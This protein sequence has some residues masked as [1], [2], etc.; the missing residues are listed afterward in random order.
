M[1]DEPL[2]GPPEE[3]RRHRLPA[4]RRAVTHK[5]SIAGHE[6]YITVG[7]YP[8]GRPGEVFVKMAKSGSALRGLMDSWATAVSMM[9]QYGIPLRVIVTKFCFARFEPDGITEHAPVRFARSPV[10]YV[11][12]YM[13]TKYLPPDELASVLPAL[14]PADAKTLPA[15]VETG[16]ACAQC[17]GMLVL[18]EDTEQYVCDT[19]GLAEGEVLPSA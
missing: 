15:G 14:T 3:P 1:A 8:D 11:V 5:F 7:L 10:D 13:A 12:R 9:L 18:L 6:G 2:S 17:G 16:P 19:C 4:E